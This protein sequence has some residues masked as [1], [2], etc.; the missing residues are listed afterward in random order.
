MKAIKP[1]G[2]LKEKFSG[3]RIGFGYHWGMCLKGLVI[4]LA[5]LL[6]TSGRSQAA[7]ID[8][9]DLLDAASSGDTITLDPANTYTFSAYEP[10][11]R[12]VYSLKKSVTL[13]GNGATI[14]MNGG[15]LSAE[16]GVTLTIDRCTF[17][18]GPG[19]PVLGDLPNP[20]PWAMMAA[21]DGSTLIVRNGTNMTGPGIQGTY[22]PPE[23]PRP[24]AGQETTGIFGGEGSSLTVTDS[25]L[26]NLTYG[27]QL[28]TAS[29]AEVARCSFW[30]VYWGALIVTDG[31][32]GS[33]TKSKV[34]VS[35]EDGV[36]FSQ[37]TGL[38][39]D[40]EFL[41]CE[42]T[43][44]TFVDSPD[45]GTVQNCL[46]TNCGDQGL[47][48]A[49]N[50]MGWDSGR[51]THNVKLINNTVIDS[52][53]CGLW[54]DYLSTAQI[55]GNIFW[56]GP[57][58]SAGM[59]LHGPKGITVDSALIMGSFKGVEV[60]SDSTPKILLSS[61]RENNLTGINA[62]NQ[63][64]ESGAQVT[65]EHNDLWWNNRSPP[66]GWNGWSVNTVNDASVYGRYCRIGPAGDNGVLG[67]GGTSCDVKSNYWG[68]TDGPGPPAGTGSG[69][70]AEG[71]NVSY[72][73]YLTEA[74]VES[75]VAT[76]VSL[77]SGGSLSWNS[78]LNAELSLTAKNGSTSI[79]DGNGI[80]GVLRVNDTDNLDSVT[81]PSGLLSGQLYVA[82]V[83]TALRLNSS[84][85]YLK[86]NLPS[87]VTEAW[88]MRREIDGSW[89]PVAAT[90]NQ[91]AHVLT[92]TPGNV[93]LLNGTFAISS[94]GC[95][96]CSGDNV[97]LTNVTFPAGRTCECV[98]T[99]S[100]TIGTGVT[101][102]ATANVTFIAP[103]IKVQPGF[104]AATGAVVRMRQQ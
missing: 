83:S 82:W 3:Y 77:P 86:F 65:L 95:P 6:A 67:Y 58:N 15:P 29:T 54:M 7:T 39:E 48:V 14:Q 75:K 101:I 91:S 87:S 98:A 27:I 79:A 88:L 97:T 23:V 99:T 17:V 11:M 61:I 20:Q 56:K 12:G 5:L 4:V 51:G 35:R 1:K 10:V 19:W 47:V 60:A 45:G 31:S 8:L 25:Y 59:R 16:N 2:S 42:M 73:P 26:N 52:Q 80:V 102:P 72:S 81:P 32:N 28:W 34:D 89:T 70:K 96:D 41:N 92:Y 78:G 44:V 13:M 90:W 18:P 63:S 66:S 62:W 84:S 24:V 74:P 94:S 38:V 33:F 103:S 68:A 22:S 100:I 43:G 71:S 49:R 30:R 55:Q 53:G 21:R 9:A 50:T 37:S 93:H 85:G 36:F 76:N 64:W 104:H 40:S 69:A 46:I 57:S